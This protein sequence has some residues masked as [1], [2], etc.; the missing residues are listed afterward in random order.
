MR[1]EIEFRNAAA[2]ALKL[3]ETDFQ[4]AVRAF[5]PMKKKKKVSD[6]FDNN[7]RDWKVLHRLPSR[8]CKRQSRVCWANAGTGDKQGR[9]AGSR[10]GRG[11]KIERN[12]SNRLEWTRR[13][14]VSTAENVR[15]IDFSSSCFGPPFQLSLA[16]IS[17]NFST[18]PPHRLFGWP[19]EPVRI[20]NNRG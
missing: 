18:A 6:F 17:T 19:C 20:I 13:R 7:M 15:F 5:N 16:K 1:C 4:P 12:F 3:F 9:R 14:G 8:K 11:G 10:E 2:R